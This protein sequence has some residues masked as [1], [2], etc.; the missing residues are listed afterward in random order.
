MKKI[1]LEEDTMQWE[2]AELNRLK[3]DKNR[4]Y[5]CP[6]Q[7]AVYS[8]TVEVT[9]YLTIMHHYGCTR[10]TC[11]HH[12]AAAGTLNCIHIAPHIFL[13][14][15]VS[16]RGFNKDMLLDFAS[17]NRCFNK[18]GPIVLQVPAVAIYFYEVA[19][20]HKLGMFESRCLDCH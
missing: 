11:S 4:K 15:A 9:L 12:L 14:F 5:N 13:D 7:L 8:Q 3:Q 1:L 6:V 20:V 2:M 10:N 19:R 17:F 16:N 18:D